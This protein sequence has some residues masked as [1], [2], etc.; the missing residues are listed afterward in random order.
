MLNHQRQ[1]GNAV[2]FSLLLILFY[3]KHSIKS[4]L[5]LNFVFFSI[6]NLLRV[7]FFFNRPIMLNLYSLKLTHKGLGE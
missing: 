7:H 5:F 1:G 2:F 6:V 3:S 4:F